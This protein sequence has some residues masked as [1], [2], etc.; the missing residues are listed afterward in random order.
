MF[1]MKIVLYRGNPHVALKSGNV[2][3][4]PE[5]ADGKH[6]SHEPETFIASNTFQSLEEALRHG[7]W[8]PDRL[9]VD[10]GVEKEWGETETSEPVEMLGDRVIKAIG[11]DQVP[12][13][14]IAKA[15]GKPVAATF[16]TLCALQRRG[17]VTCTNSDNVTLWK[18]L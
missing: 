7:Y 2:G 4:N 8:V 18:A 10:A 16:S 14:T 12:T 11:Q 6:Y 15:I 13:P 1:K 3:P 9:L 5:H 17:L